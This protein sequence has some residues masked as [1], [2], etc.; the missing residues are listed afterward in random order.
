MPMDD[1]TDPYWAGR[2]EDVLTAFE[3]KL[4]L[5]RVTG[6]TIG[7][8]GSIVETKAR[9]TIYGSLQTWRRTRN[10]SEDSFNSS[11]RTGKLLVKYR[12]QLNDGDIV[13]K[14]NDFYRIIN[15]NDYDYAEVHD[16]EVQRLGLDEIQTYNFAEYLEEEFPEII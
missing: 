6:K 3:K 11:A 5:Y 14:N 12:Y 8:D 1:Y 16:Y 15:T 9:Y 10:Y 2:L 7:T 4:Y 13:Q